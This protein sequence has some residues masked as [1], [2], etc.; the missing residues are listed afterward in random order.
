MPLLENDIKNKGI[1]AVTLNPCIDV[2][3]SVESLIK[4]GL[5]R[6]KDQRSD[7]SGKG[8]N[9]AA[10]FSVLGG[11]ATASGWLFDSDRQAFETYLEHY[12]VKNACV[13]VEGATRR[14]TK[15][16][17]ISD[18]SITEVNASGEPVDA[19]AIERLQNI[20]NAK[21]L[22]VGAMVFS[23]SVTKN[24]PPEIYA[25]LMNT[26][27]ARPFLILDTEKQWLCE[28][29]K[30]SPD[31]IKPNIKEL[32]DVTGSKAKTHKQIV[33]T[34]REFAIPFGINVIAVTLGSEGALM[35]TKKESWYSKPS[36]VEVQSTTGA[37]DCFIAG[38][39]TAMKEN[40]PISEWLRYGTAAAGGAVE[41]QGTQPPS[42]D[43]FE[44]LL[45]A[46]E[47]SRVD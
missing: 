46:V 8:F 42:K 17:D 10:A 35:V 2:T 12:N 40:R 25:Q 1:M 30:A 16:R 15:I 20:L 23:G 21:A 36:K 43:R 38:I 3:V 7:P 26:L 34:A 28:G 22:H 14:N 44:R 45:G 4:G 19:H 24:L 32:L 47:V 33:H 13:L 18:Q 27:P 31:L 9:V 37:G 11:K 6:I 29:I 41:K 5:N 39:L